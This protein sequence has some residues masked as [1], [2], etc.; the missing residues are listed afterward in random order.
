MTQSVQKN[1]NLFISYAHR[2]ME[3]IDWI[4]RLKI[5]LAPLRTSDVTIWEDSQIPAGTKWQQGIEAALQDADVAILL[6]GPGFFASEF[7]AKVELPRLLRAAESNGI[8]IFPLV[9]GYCRYANSV[10]EEF[11]AFNDPQVPME[12]LPAADQN[13]CL[14]ALSIAADGALRHRRQ[15]HGSARLTTRTQSTSLVEPVTRIQRHL[16][17]TYRAFVAQCNRR[18]VLVAG[19]TAR[20]GIDND[21]EYERFFIRFYSKMTEAERFEFDQIRALTEGP[22]VQGNK[23]IL[24]ILESYPT[25]LDELP[26]LVDLRQHLVFWVNK[27]ERVFVKTPGMCLLY[28]GVEDE[29]A[30]PSG[31]DRS[32]MK[33]LRNSKV[34]AN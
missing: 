27:Y 26:I 33:W 8:K 31:L 23:A 17:D 30:F 28:T 4:D 18:D 29:V 11:Q 22:L 1:Q 5:Y 3:P 34:K 13:K 16:S 20:S 7:I 32:I 14:N 15:A 9:V 2:D 24:Q 12:A 19:M 25:L 21:L 6:V 10:L